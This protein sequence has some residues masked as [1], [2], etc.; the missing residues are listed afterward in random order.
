MGGMR[1]LHQWWPRAAL[2]LDWDSGMKTRKGEKPACQG[3]RPKAGSRAAVPG[4]GGKSRA[5]RG[6]QP[7]LHRDLQ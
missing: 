1:C 6:K 3:L 7:S 4:E 5:M 2:P